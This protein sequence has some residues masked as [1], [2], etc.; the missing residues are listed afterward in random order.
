MDR[1]K[2][3]VKILFLILFIISVRASLISGQEITIPTLDFITQNYSLSNLPLLEMRARLLQNKNELSV[4]SMREEPA[5]NSVVIIPAAYS[6][7]D[8]A[9]FCK[10][11]VKMEKLF[12]FP[13]KMRLGE[14]NYAEMREGKPHTPDILNY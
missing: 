4:P 10:L 9:I 12:K 2:S 3:F 1:M 11:E 7:H 13:V 6:Y 14:V 5:L 8:L